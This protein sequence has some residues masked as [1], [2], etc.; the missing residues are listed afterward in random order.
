MIMSRRGKKDY[1]RDRT[2]AELMK[3]A[4]Q[5]LAYEH[6]AREGYRI[7]QVETPG[8]LRKTP[9]GEAA[10]KNKPSSRRNHK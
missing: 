10:S 1:M 2:F 8:S 5:T 3:A 4:E 6:G 9:A 7:G